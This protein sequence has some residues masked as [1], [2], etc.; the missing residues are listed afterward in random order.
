MAQ[1]HF[2]LVETI[3]PRDYLEFRDKLFPA[4]G[5][6]SFQMREM[7]IL[8][9]LEESKRARLG[10][11]SALK[12]LQDLAPRS[13]GGQHAWSK[14]EAAGEEITL[15]AALHRWLYRTPIYGSTPSDDND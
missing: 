8:L 4:S 14:V 5:F 11:V 12:Y 3:T 13:A 15:R 9:G 6:Q 7:E 2:H 1:Q 10:E